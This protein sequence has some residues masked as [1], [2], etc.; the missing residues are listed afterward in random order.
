MGSFNDSRIAHENHE[1]NSGSTRELLRE[2][3]CRF[4][5]PVQCGSARGLAQSETSRWC[6]RFDVRAL[7]FVLLLL[8]TALAGSG[9]QTS[10]RRSLFTV[11][12]PG[13]TVRQG[14]ALWRPG[15]QFPELA[16]DIVMAWD[17]DG[18]CS[19]HFDKTPLPL[20]FAQTTRTAW[21][22]Q[23]PPRRLSL[24]GR[25]APPSRFAWLYLHAALA[26]QA[27]PKHL[28]FQRKPDGNWRLENTR[29]GETLEGFLTP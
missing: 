10:M 16:G 18:R 19:V 1:P 21:L 20:V 29:T 24:A 8:A 17:T 13:W 22:I 12:G 15:R 28:A 23:F 14:Q 3:F 25:G 7:P 2:L 11:S 4:S 26:G 5:T 9:C 6:G 27:L